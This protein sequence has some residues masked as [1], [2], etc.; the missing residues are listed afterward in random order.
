MA[1]SNREKES[2][3]ACC[4]LFCLLVMFYWFLHLTDRLCFCAL[5]VEAKN[6]IDFDL[7][8]LSRS[9]VGRAGRCVLIFICCLREEDRG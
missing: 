4:A 5:V 2:L 3:A 9:A 1:I 7:C 8:G 6:W